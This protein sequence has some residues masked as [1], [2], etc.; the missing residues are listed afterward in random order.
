MDSQATKSAKMRQLFELGLTRTQVAEIMRV[1]YGFVQNVY[2]KWVLT[3]MTAASRPSFVLGEFNR[4]F[5]IEIE[6]FGVERNELRSALDAEGLHF[7][8]VGAD[9]SIRGTNSFELVS[10]ILVGL[11]GLAQLEKV[12]RILAA[13]RAKVNK[14]CGLHVHIEARSFTLPTWKNLFASYANLEGTIDTMM[15]E[16]RRG[17]SN[18]YCRSI[19]GYTERAQAA[20]TVRELVR[21]L[22]NRYHKVNTLAFSE[23]GTVEFRQHSG[24]VEYT[25][26]SNW[27]LFLH[28]LISYSEQGYRVSPAATFEAAEA[29]APRPVSE[30]Y[31]QRINDLAA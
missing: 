1:G 16:S 31:F 18:T 13:K 22:P 12:C 17:Q 21:A 29:F 24:T 10:P 11:D 6:A 8:R 3:Q 20:T 9:G 23:H 4:R 7:W 14:S 28:S 26:I 2:A 15:P 30:F 19:V 27:V 5:G 25:K